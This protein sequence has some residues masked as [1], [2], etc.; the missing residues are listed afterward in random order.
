[1]A[2][3]LHQLRC[4]VSHY[5]Q[6]FIYP[7]WCRISAINRMEWVDKNPKT[8]KPTNTRKYFGPPKTYTQKKEP[9]NSPTRH[10]EDQDT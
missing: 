8:S 3:I 2:E 1:M 5:L 6:G 7:N 9:P 10:L 4:S